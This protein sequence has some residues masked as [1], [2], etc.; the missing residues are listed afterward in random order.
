MPEDPIEHVVLVDE[1]DQ[2]IGTADKAAIHHGD[3][4]LHRGFSVFLFDRSGNLLL[5]QRNLEKKTWPG[6]WSNSCCGH[7]QQGESTT[8]AMQ[9]RIEQELGLAGV[10]VTVVLPGYRYRYAHGGVVENEFCPVAIGVIDQEPI[11]NPD[12]VNAVR[13]IRW[14]TFLKEIAGLNEYSE[15]CIEEAQL[16]MANDTFRSFHAALETTA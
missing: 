7:P 2:P 12:E 13:W 8:Q 3:T 16:L 5:Q 11:P 6:V 14:E 15:W 9:R 4:P 1:N 10:A